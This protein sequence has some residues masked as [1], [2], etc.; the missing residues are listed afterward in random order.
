MQVS[1]GARL[2]D[3]CTTKVEFGTITA[4]VPVTLSL[5]HP[6]LDGPILIAPDKPMEGRRPN[7][8]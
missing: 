2:L 6:M 1:P 8:G 4:G 7:L 5:S 3:S